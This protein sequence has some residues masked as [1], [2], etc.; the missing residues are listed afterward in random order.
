M[1][2]H[3]KTIAQIGEF[4][5]IERIK[6]IIPQADHQDVYPGI[7]DDTAVIK[8]SPQKWLLATCDIQIE[9]IHFRLKHISAYQL[10][11]R[12]AAVNL[13]DIAS[14]GGTPKYALV[15]LGLPPDTEVHQFDE[16]FTGMG[17]ELAKYSAFIIGGNLAHSARRLIIDIFLL[18]EVS[19][20]MIL[21]RSG[22]RAGD[23]IFVTGTLGASAAGFYVLEK[24]G[25]DFPD[26]YSHLVTAHLQPIP[27]IEVGQRIARSGYATA[28]ID[29]SDGI[30]SDLKHICDSSGVGAA[31]VEEDIPVSDQMETVAAMASKTGLE[32]ALHGGEDYE[33]LFTMKADTPAEVIE[34]IAAETQTEISE[35]GRIVPAEEGYYLMTTANERISLQPKGWDHFVI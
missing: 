7:G 5:L 9:D 16:F 18:G 26:E 17:E 19:P 21:L 13:S 12:A 1:T 30:A 28:M 34:Q 35:V 3:L 25:K 32:L 27:K 10:G 23:R 29:L 11:C 6:K 33:L 15:S 31:L 2:T 24:F 14:M 20:D 4:P 8:I 22:A